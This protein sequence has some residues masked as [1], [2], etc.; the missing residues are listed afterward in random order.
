M[1]KNPEFHPMESD[2]PDWVHEEIL[3]NQSADYY[4]RLNSMKKVVQEGAFT[5]D[6]AKSL[7]SK[8]GDLDDIEF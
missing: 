7:Y 8:A 5:L 3:N 4:A 2:L 6:E 1:K